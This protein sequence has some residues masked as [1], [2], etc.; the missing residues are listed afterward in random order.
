VRKPVGW[1]LAVRPKLTPYQRQEA[2]RRLATGETQTDIARSYGVSH[3]TIGQGHEAAV[4]LGRNG[5]VEDGHARL[6]L[7]APH[8][9]ARSGR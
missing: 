6:R 5:G 1:N 7:A 3:V 2:L 8:G 4:P 9:A